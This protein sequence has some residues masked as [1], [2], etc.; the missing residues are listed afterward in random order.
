MALMRRRR[1][2]AHTITHSLTRHLGL[3]ATGVPRGAEVQ[4]WGCSV[5]VSFG[6]TQ[7]GILCG[8]AAREARLAPLI[9]PREPPRTLPLRGALLSGEGENP[10]VATTRGCG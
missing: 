9:K 1:V 7:R 8:R 3:A 2:V 6:R 5:C 10:R 4:T